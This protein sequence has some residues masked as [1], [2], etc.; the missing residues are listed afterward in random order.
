MTL[1]PAVFLFALAAC[2]RVPLDDDPIVED[3][4]TDTSSGGETPTDSG[5]EDPDLEPM[6]GCDPGDPNTCPMGQKCSA[7]SEGGV[8]QNDFQCVNDDG[9]LPPGEECE[10]APGTGQD[11]CSAGTVCLVASTEATLGNCLEVCSNDSTCEP[12]KCI[13][14][15]YT[16]TP[17]CADACDPL[18]PDCPQ[19]RACLQSDDR[20]V[21]GML[22][23]ETD[24]GQT[25][26]NCDYFNLRGCAEG[27]ACLT[28]ALVPNCQSSACCTNVC[29]LNLGDEQCASPG[30]CKSLFTEPAPGFELLGACYV[31]T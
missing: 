2:Q 25:G 18:V 12:G 11:G 10:P 29:D 7:L 17:F 21:C 19:G 16:L 8:A 24:I 4:D 9:M 23:D 1:R 22:L 31:P 5:D 13:E 15:P 6:F 3:T 26:D 14:S 27:Y 28:G 20:F 30:L